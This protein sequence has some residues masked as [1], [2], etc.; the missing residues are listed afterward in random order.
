MV[1]NKV[2]VK[3]ESVLIGLKHSKAITKKPDI[4]QTC[5]FCYPKNTGIFH[6]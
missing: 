3:T 6:F 5:G 1:K 4:S 2:V